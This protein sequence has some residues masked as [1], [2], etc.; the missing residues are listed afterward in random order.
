[1]RENLNMEQPREIK[2]TLPENNIGFAFLKP[3]YEELLPD[4]ESVMYDHGLSVIYD[5][6][7]VLSG[8]AVDYIYRDN[9]ESHFYPKMKEYLT[10]NPVR[11][12]VIEG[13]GGET[14]EVLVNLK[15][16]LRQKFQNEDRILPDEIK[17]FD[18]NKH[19]EQDEMVVKLTQKNVIH[20]ADD[21]A[22][23]I[24]S[25]KK[26]LG[27]KFD[28]MVRKGNLPAELWDIFSKSKKSDQRDN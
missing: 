23:A 11:V 25:L 15:G 19:P 16:L 1:M 17:L 9:R 7:M 28:N 10:S 14:Q 27:K 13:S 6:S 20:C 22:E 26:I 21:G 4:I 12:L 5:D 8:E 3:G 2:E 18:A 24:E